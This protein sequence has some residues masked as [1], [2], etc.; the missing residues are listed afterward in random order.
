[1]WLVILGI[2]LVC[3]E[4]VWRNHDEFEILWKL[5]YQKNLQLILGGKNILTKTT[6][7]GTFIV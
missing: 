4:G 3:R 6:S 1:M 5:R 2:L 7:T